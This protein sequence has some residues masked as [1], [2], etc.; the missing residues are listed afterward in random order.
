MNWT[1]KMVAT[2]AYIQTD[3]SGAVDD[4]TIQSLIGSNSAYQQDLLVYAANPQRT[5]NADASIIED[6]VA[7]ASSEYVDEMTLHVL[8]YHFPSDDSSRQALMIYLTGYYWYY[9][10]NGDYPAWWDSR[11]DP[12]KWWAVRIVALEHEH[13]HQTGVKYL[14]LKLYFTRW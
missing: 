12:S 1:I 6:E 3:T 7:I 14:R 4:A 2:N 11:N 10:R 5:L 9:V 8:P 13:K